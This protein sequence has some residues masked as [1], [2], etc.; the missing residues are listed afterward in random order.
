MNK[1]FCFIFVGCF[2][3]LS[4]SQK[5]LSV[6]EAVFIALENNYKI[7]VIQKQVEI[8]E[9]NNKWS[10]AGLFPTVSLNATFSNTIIDNTKN[11]FTFTP[12]IILNQGINPSLNTTWNI[13]SGFAVKINKERLELLENQS[14]GNA[15]VLIENTAQDVLKAYFTAVLQKKRLELYQSVMVFSSK[16]LKYY[17][18]KE[19]YAKS[20][21]LELLQYKN[22]YFTDS[23]NVLLQ[24]ISYNNALRNLN[25]LMNLP[26]SDQNN[27]QQFILTD[28]LN[29]PLN[30][31]DFNTVREEMLR[32]NQ[33]ILNQYISI[34]LQKSN[35]ELQKSF[36][37]PTLS[38]QAGVTPSF[39]HFRDIKDESLEIS[40][41]SLSYYGNINLRYTIFNNW[42]SKRAIEVA[43]IQE[44]IV[45]L[46]R[47]SLQQT[48]SNTLQNLIEMYQVRSQLL[49]LSEENVN[50]AI[51]MN[52]LSQKRFELGSINSVELF[53]IQNSYQ[54]TLIQYYENQFNRIDT[55]L[56]I[57]KMTG[58]LGLEYQK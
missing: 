9:K 57:Y 55:Y 2:Y 1:Y 50:Y 56:E 49:A 43:K 24:Q 34:E 36:L 33:N 15:L 21:S 7:Q 12:G 17:E 47:L 37:Y 27:I 51:K 11:P 16:R 3:F 28:S 58:K 25:T 32:S 38:F 42:K 5:P 6:K 48:L 20:N 26:E 45:E 18:L 22:Q 40:T 19:K 13:F 29:L 4:Y 35:V 31:L 54:N 44:E 8:A 52:E 41:Q 39:S 23:T 14:K 10:E 30:I 53:N 46:D